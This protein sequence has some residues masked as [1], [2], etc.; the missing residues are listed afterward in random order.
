MRRILNVMPLLLLAAS[1][2][3]FSA[4]PDSPSPGSTHRIQVFRTG[5]GEPRVRDAVAART[6][7]PR[8]PSPSQ[9]KES[10]RPYQA[11]KPGE[12]TP[13]G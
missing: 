5:K 4:Q 3:V 10:T 2:P 7:S 11:G 6:A 8:T 1:L 13:K 12:G 9:D